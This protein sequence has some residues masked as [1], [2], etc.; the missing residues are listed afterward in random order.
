M[1]GGLSTLYSLFKA[2]PEM[3]RKSL[4]KKQKCYNT[5]KKKNGDVSNPASDSPNRNWKLTELYL[6]GLQ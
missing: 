3:N 5:K 1:N 2:K 4:D 6:F